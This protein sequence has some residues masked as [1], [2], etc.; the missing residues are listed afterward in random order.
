MCVSP[1]YNGKQKKKKKTETV[2]FVCRLETI[3]F[4]SE[5]ECCAS[6]PSGGG[7]GGGGVEEEEWRSEAKGKQRTPPAALSLF[8]FL[9]FRGSF[10]TA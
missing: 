1:H 9:Q 10:I 4:V 3:K 7:G 5:C 2:Q 6:T 8:S